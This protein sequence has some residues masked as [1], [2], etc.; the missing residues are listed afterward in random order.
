MFTGYGV[1]V[2]LIIVWS[3]VARRHEHWMSLPDA[4]NALTRRR[5]V[6]I[7]VVVGWIW[8]GWHLF[9]RGSGAFK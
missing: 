1:I 4:F 5:A 8:L 2:A 6:R 3:T 9:A 7:L